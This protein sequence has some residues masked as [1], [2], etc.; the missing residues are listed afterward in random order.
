MPGR[1]PLTSVPLFNDPFCEDGFCLPTE[2]SAGDAWVARLRGSVVR[3]TDADFL[4]YK[5][6]CYSFDNGFIYLAFG[7]GTYAKQIY[8]AKFAPT[9]ETIWVKQMP[10]AYSNQYEGG[11]VHMTADESSNLLFLG[12]PADVTYKTDIRPG[13][14]SFITTRGYGAACINASSGY[15]NWT[16]T[17]LNTHWQNN[18]NGVALSGTPRLGPIRYDKFTSRLYSQSFQGF[19]ENQLLSMGAL[20]GVDELSTRWSTDYTLPG[21]F[22][23]PHQSAYIVDKGY[24]GLQLYTVS[25]TIRSFC[26]L[27]PGS[28][29]YPYQVGYGTTG[30]IH[31]AKFL[32]N[33]QLFLWFESNEIMIIGAGRAVIDHVK[34]P[35]GVSSPDGSSY[36]STIP[37]PY[38][39]WPIAESEPGDEDRGVAASINYEVVLVVQEGKIYMTYPAHCGTT[40]VV[41][42]VTMFSDQIQSIDSISTR[43]D[44]SSTYLD[45]GAWT[46][47]SKYSS[48]NIS[49]PRITGAIGG[50]SDGFW[51]YVNREVAVSSVKRSNINTGTAAATFSLGGGISSQTVGPNASFRAVET[52]IIPTRF[53][54]V[55]SLSTAYSETVPP[56]GA[57]PLVFETGPDAPCTGSGTDLPYWI[58]GTSQG[59]A[60]PDVTST[61]IFDL[62]SY[63][64]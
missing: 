5:S 26:T 37:L 51:G 30:R 2:G 35:P 58:A 55:E 23:N 18:C 56:A 57:V 21:T 50:G 42:T 36:Y 60:P 17:W 8:L 10:F 63:T 24:L 64:I 32:Q 41:F 25:K 4:S 29:E 59:V 62:Y 11:A 61:L 16:S 31:I 47:A 43:L 13:F 9:G 12:Y 44:S 46:G 53:E 54:L 19:G 27:T 15:V 6:N 40:C 28:Y 39:L 33:G 7:Y 52:N 45:Q 1:F 3:P 48:N 20:T 34:F 49:Q 22:Y 14:G 38:T